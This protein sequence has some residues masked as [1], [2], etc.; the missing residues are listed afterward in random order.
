MKKVFD[1]VISDS[2]S[3]YKIV[4]KMPFLPKKGQAIGCWM[5]KNID[6]TGEQTEL[7]WVIGNIYSVI[8]EFEPDG[9]FL[10]TEINIDTYK[11][12]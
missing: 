9:T 11:D 8:H 4:T 2:E 6:D 12:N 10:T 5:P 1:V 3:D 7:V